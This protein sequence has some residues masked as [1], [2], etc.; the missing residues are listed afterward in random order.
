MVHDDHFAR[1]TSA[2]TP[3]AFKAELSYKIL[4]RRDNGTSLLQV[5]LQ[6]GRYHQIRAQFAHLGHPVVGD[7]KYGSSRSYKKGWI[8]LQHYCL[9]IQH[10]VSKEEMKFVSKFEL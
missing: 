8:A 10:P 1:I 6:S 2:R 7:T 5:N 3:G 9:T 4:Q